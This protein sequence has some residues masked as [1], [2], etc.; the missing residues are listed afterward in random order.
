MNAIVAVD[1]NWGIGRNNDLLCH[2]PGDLKYYKEKTLGKC[3]VFGQKTLESL[4]GS[5]PLPKR[6]HI[7]LSDDP[8]FEVSP[9]EGCECR[10]VHSKGEVMELVAEY[11][12]RAGA[13]VREEGGSPMEI[14]QAASEAVFVCGGASI[15][16]LFLDDC[17]TFYITK[18]H[19]VFDADRFF[20]NLDDM[21]LKVSWE[22][23][24]QIDEAT[25]MEY[26]FQKYERK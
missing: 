15:Y 14:Q 24:V 8:L 26:T 16:E 11:E 25:G 2:L 21:G 10:V 9:R 5:R 7:V 22:S 3:V 23:E 6:N 20:P 19:K 18:M 1:E 13:K 17:D 4:P 12:A